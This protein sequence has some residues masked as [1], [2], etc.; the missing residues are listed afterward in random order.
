MTLYIAL[1]SLF[2]ALNLIGAQHRDNTGENSCEFYARK[3]GQP[4]DGWRVL[5]DPTGSRCIREPVDLRC[6][7]QQYYDPVR[8]IIT[9]NF[10][11]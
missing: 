9:D 6:A 3:L 7:G 4:L 10:K 11:C 1:L 8:L 5:Q 2:A